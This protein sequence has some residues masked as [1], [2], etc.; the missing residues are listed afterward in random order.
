MD[1]VL[2]K[3]LDLKLTTCHKVRNHIER[4]FRLIPGNHMTSVV[5]L[6]EG[7]A[8]CRARQPR[9]LPLVFLGGV[10]VLLAV[11]FQSQR[12]RCVPFIITDEID[13][14]RIDQSWNPVVQ[15]ISNIPTEIFHP[16]RMELGSGGWCVS[17]MSIGE[18]DRKR[19][20]RDLLSY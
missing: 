4:N 6:Q 5:D 3:P 18:T 11:P 2:P 9:T 19:E 17:I 8:V 20:V 16:I 1:I 13:I 12:P 7:Q 14:S 10:E 15:Q